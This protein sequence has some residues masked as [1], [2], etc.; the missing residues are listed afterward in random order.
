MNIPDVCHALNNLTINPK[1]GI[2]EVIEIQAMETGY[3]KTGRKATQEEVDKENEALGV[4]KPTAR[5]MSD[6]SVFGWQVYANCLQSH[7][8]REKNK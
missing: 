1:T 8:E 7:K 5:A 2:G 4:D 3:Y 6:A